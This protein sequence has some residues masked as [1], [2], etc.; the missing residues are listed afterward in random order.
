MRI[1]SSNFFQ[2]LRDREIIYQTTDHHGD[3]TL[4][5][6]L[7]KPITLY[8]GFDP[9][10]DSLHLGNL[11]PLLTLRRF[12]LAGHTPILVLG[13]AT[14]M[15]G[16]PSGKSQERNLQTTE[17]VEKNLQGIKKV[18][19]KFLD[20]DK[21]K[22]NPAIIVNNHDFYA[23]MNVL[24][25]LREVG[26][27]FTVNHMSA[28]DSVKS[29]M[30]DREVGISYTEFSYMLL[31]AYDY[32]HLYKNLGCTL[33]IGASDQWGNITA[34]TELIRRKEAHSR[35]DEKPD[36]SAHPAFGLTHPLILRSD[37]QKFGKSEKGAVWLS[38]DK[39]S[40]FQ[41][42]Q[43]FIQVPD[44]IVMKLVQYLTFIPTSEFTAMEEK[45]KTE[46]ERKAAQIRLAEELTRLV[47]GEVALTRVER[48]TKALFGTEIKELDLATLGEVF[49]D[50]PTTTKAKSDLEVG[51]TLIDLLVDTALFQSRGAARKEIP[52]GGVYLNNER[53]TDPAFI[54][55]AENLIAGSALVLRKGKKNYHLV[56]FS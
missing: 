1:M 56:K 15:I 50:A 46:P 34:G 25:F 26:K 36:E 41:F 30:E 54:V 55:K 28:K 48:A 45:L 52:A 37:G 13:G 35:G 22:P 18:A 7:E 14:G 33:Q 20:F 2:D 17:Q 19:E 39:T 32:Y 11:F 40:A 31:Q 38:A 53:I 5:K 4:A 24:N 51:L 6:H 21:N 44:D 43:F 8:C 12:Q 49:A 42:Y 16:D 47:H 27:H 10:A 29:R 23:N 3:T 9:T